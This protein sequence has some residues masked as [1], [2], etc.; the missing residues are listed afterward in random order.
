MVAA[1]SPTRFSHHTSYT[2]DGC[3]LNNYDLALAVVKLEPGALVVVLKFRD[4]VACLQMPRQQRC[5]PDP[6]P[7][8]DAA[9][10]PFASLPVQL[11]GRDLPGLPRPSVGWSRVHPLPRASMSAPRMSATLPRLPTAS[12]LPRP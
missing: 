7:Q 12:L 5:L 1:R 4:Y 8:R 10:Q 9:R 6:Q 3:L 11:Q 2:A